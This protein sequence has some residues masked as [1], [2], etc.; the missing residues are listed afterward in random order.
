MDRIM[1]SQPVVNQDGTIM[2]EQVTMVHANEMKNGIKVRELKVIQELYPN[3]DL[4]R[5]TI[6]QAKVN[7]ENTEL[8]AEKPVALLE[9]EKKALEGLIQ[10]VNQIAL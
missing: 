10:M 1:Y 3:I 4:L 9:Q 7:Y 8:Q 6:R 2:I 5:E